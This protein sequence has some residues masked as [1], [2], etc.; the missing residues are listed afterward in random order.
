MQVHHQGAES[1]LIIG[2]LIAQKKGDSNVI[3]MLFQPWNLKSK[4]NALTFTDLISGWIELQRCSVLDENYAEL[5]L[6]I[7]YFKITNCKIASFNRFYLAWFSKISCH[8]S[9]DFLILIYTIVQSTKDRKLLLS[10][11]QLRTS[12]T[13]NSSYQL[14]D[15]MRNVWIEIERRLI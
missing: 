1:F 9:E 12:S 2:K 5:M 8:G 3:L 10:V 4:L 11:V 13:A 7:Y 14:R 6:T 15:P